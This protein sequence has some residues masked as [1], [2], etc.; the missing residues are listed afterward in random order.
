MEQADGT[1]TQYGVNRSS[2]KTLLSLVEASLGHAGDVLQNVRE[3]IIQAGDGAYGPAQRRII[4]DDLRSLRAE[5]LGIANSNDGEG[6]Y[7]FA[8]YRSDVMPFADSPG[9][10]QY[11]GDE[12]QRLIQVSASR[13]MPVSEAG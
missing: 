11:L 13:Q 7:Q 6:H 3:H 8:G 5:L 1:N 4:A 2:A 10:M 12:G 9:G